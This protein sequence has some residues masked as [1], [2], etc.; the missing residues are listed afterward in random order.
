M[1]RNARINYIR[2]ARVP[3]KPWDLIIYAGIIVAVIF[4]IISLNRPAGAALEVSYYDRTGARRTI[5]LPL[6]TER[7]VYYYAGGGTEHLPDGA[8]PLMSDADLPGD[9]EFVIVTEGGAAW[10]DESHCPNQICVNSGKIRLVQQSIF[11][12]PYRITLTVT[13]ESIADVSV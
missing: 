5:E 1:D 13:G 6:S 9:A 7:R 8:I 11:C 12:S 10:V 3:F 2:A 4:I